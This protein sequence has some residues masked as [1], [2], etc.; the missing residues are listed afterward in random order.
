MEKMEKILVIGAGLPNNLMMQSLKEKY[1]EDIVV[2]TPEEA[3]KQGLKD[4]ANTKFKITDPYHDVREMYK[5]I[6]LKGNHQ[7]YKRQDRKIGR[8]DMCPCGSGKK[9]KRCCC[10]NKKD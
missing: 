8:N 4:F 3:K 5:P 1:G 7:P 2:V 9:Y 6:P 10:I